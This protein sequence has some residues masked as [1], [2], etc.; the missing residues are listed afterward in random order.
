MKLLGTP[1]DLLRLK[2]AFISRIFPIRSNTDA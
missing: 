1:I 2:N